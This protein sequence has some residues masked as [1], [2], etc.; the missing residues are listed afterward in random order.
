[1]TLPHYPHPEL[2]KWPEACEVVEPY[3]REMVAVEP[4]T[5]ALAAEA[6]ETN[7]LLPE[8]FS[9]GA[10][11]ACPGEK[12]DPW[13]D[14]RHLRCGNTYAIDAPPWLRDLIL[15]ASLGLE[16]HKTVQGLADELS[17]EAHVFD[18]K[19]GLRGRERARILW[20]VSAR[21][22]LTTLP[23]SYGGAETRFHCWNEPG[24]STERPLSCYAVR[25]GWAA[26][27]VPADAK[28]I[29][30]GYGENLRWL[31]R[32]SSIDGTKVCALLSQLLAL[33]L[34]VDR[35]CPDPKTGESHV[36]LCF[37]ELAT[38]PQRPGEL[39]A[40]PWS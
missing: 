1:V 24:Y 25:H 32:T 4:D 22:V 8:G 18:F 20:R 5:W 21:M 9:Q 13:S 37:E 27:P 15:V 31:A 38:D 16:A 26:A 17:R 3:I 2:P 6:F 11:W 12:N 40:G 29:R 33:G 23:G 28:E 36:A 7:G 30:R 10:R 35:V 34:S 14:H 39:R 19:R